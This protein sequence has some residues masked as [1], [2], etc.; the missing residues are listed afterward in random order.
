MPEV[1]VGFRAVV[2]DIY[3]AVLERIHRSRVDVE[4]RVELLNG[5]PEPAELQKQ[6]DG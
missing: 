3:L 5:H 2:R 6:A 4:I 1:Q